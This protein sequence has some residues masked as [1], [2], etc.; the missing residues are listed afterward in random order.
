MD[1]ISKNHGSLFTADGDYFVL[2]L[3]Q[4]GEIFLGNECF[5]ARVKMFQC[6]SRLIPKYENANELFQGLFS[7]IIRVLEELPSEEKVSEA[8]EVIKVTAVECPEAAIVF[9]SVVGEPLRKVADLLLHGKT[10]LEMC[11][12]VME[13][14]VVLYAPKGGRELVKFEEALPGIRWMLNIMAETGRCCRGYFGVLSHLREVYQE[15]N[16]FAGEISEVFVKKA[17]NR[18]EAPVAAILQM[19]SK[20]EHCEVDVEWIVG[21][22]IEGLGSYDCEVNLASVKCLIRVFREMD[23]GIFVSLMEVFGGKLLEVVFKAMTDGMHKNEIGC[24]AKFLRKLCGFMSEG[25]KGSEGWKDL[26]VRS[27]REVMGVEPEEGLFEEFGRR[28]NRIWM[29]GKEVFEKLVVGFLIMM[30]KIWPGD[31][32]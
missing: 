4:N 12:L 31:K 15:M 20:F 27:M 29:E 14:C 28:M 8:L 26:L 18:G 17:M 22:G 9:V 6:T 25:K 16:E 30:K 7:P 24:Y 21:V 10:S 13:T 23:T 3:S 1:Y 2:T 19:L 11:E 32:S 5:E